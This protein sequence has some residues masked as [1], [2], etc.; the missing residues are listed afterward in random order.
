M[1]IFIN[2]YLVNNNK[3]NFFEVYKNCWAILKGILFIMPYILITFNSILNL[4]Y[5][6][7]INYL[8]DIINMIVDREYFMFNDEAN[9]FLQKNTI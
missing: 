9:L 6:H 2:F 1:A 8:V 7:D 4:T 3:H 5:Y